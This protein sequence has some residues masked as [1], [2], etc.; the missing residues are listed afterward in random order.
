LEARDEV[1]E[2]PRRRIPR[3][4]GEL[5]RQLRESGEPWEPNP[6]LRDEE[7]LPM[8]ARGGLEP[9]EGPPE[10]EQ[11]QPFEGDLEELLRESPP[12]NPF[13]RERWQEQ[14]LLRDDEA[15][16]GGGTPGEIEERQEESDSEP[17]E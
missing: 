14:E 10:T 5:R 11:P 9:G 4:V 15:G 3:T 16:P 12:A 6:R 17:G 13:V 1:T 2:H 8:P 7:P